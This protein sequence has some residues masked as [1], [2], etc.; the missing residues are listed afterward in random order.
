MKTL[1]A[2]FFFVSLSSFVL[3]QKLTIFPGQGVGSL[4][5]NK[6]TKKDVKKYIGKGKPIKESFYFC[7]Q[8]RGTI[9]K[10]IYP[11]IGIELLYSNLINPKGNDTLNTIRILEYSTL[12]TEE[13]IGIGS[14]RREV[15]KVFGKTSLSRF[16]ILL[17][18][19]EVYHSLQYNEIEF[20]FDNHYTSTIDTLD[21]KVIQINMW[22][23]N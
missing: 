20:I 17:S 23:N 7:S 4:E 10:F 21:Y 12:K 2:L 1:W 19:N 13:G 5:I 22:K 3:E 14:S 18:P 11:Q 6:T 16:D 9:K 15:E 8:G